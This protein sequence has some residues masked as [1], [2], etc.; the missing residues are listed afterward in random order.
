MLAR[1]LLVA[2]LAIAAARPAAAQCAQWDDQFAPAQQGLNGP[3]H[4]TVVFDDGSGLALYAAGTFTIAG[5]AP[6]GRIA[7]W[8]G[9]QWTALGNPAGTNGN[10]DALCVFDDGTGPALYAGGEFTMIGGVAASHIARW[11]NLAWSTLVDAGEGLPGAVLSLAA[12]DGLYAAGNFQIAGGD[13]VNHIA[14]WDGAS[15][16]P[17]GSGIDDYRIY[18]MVVFDDGAGPSLFAGGMFASGIARWDGSSW[19]GLGTGLNGAVYALAAHNDGSG[20][21]LYAGGSFSAAGGVPAQRVARW[22]GTTWSALG[23]P[24]NGMEARVRTLLRFDDGTGPQLYAG[25]EFDAAGSASAHR[26][27]RWD[28]V[29]WSPLATPGNGVDGIVWSLAVFDD[30][31]DLAPDLYVLGAFTTAGAFPS[32]HIAEW[33]GCAN[34]PIAYCFGDGALAACPCA[35]TGASGRG[36]ENSSGTG[37]A[38]LTSFGTTTPDTLVL[39]QQGELAT[40]LSIFLQGDVQLATQAPFGDGL[41]CVGGSLKRLYVKAAS[42]G[43]VYAPEPGDPSITTRSAL[44]G[45]SIASG[46]MRQY[47]VY[48]RD[49]SATFCP[50]PLG[51]TFNVGNALRVVW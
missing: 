2:L 18:T 10:V 11:K 40:A 5:G 6:V 41:R 28:G 39:T 24:G 7:K 21:A 17:V 33:H 37:G 45:D 35:N 42:A 36:C 47:Q 34:P 51:S 31:A 38:R 9:S 22:N 30:G 13:Q 49:P 44:L 25:G 50:S 20:L 4:S 43:A 19:S 29:A 26:V 32:A 3:V 46:S 16:S 14:R 27:A 15:W 8:N 23:S 12:F 1:S 48:Y